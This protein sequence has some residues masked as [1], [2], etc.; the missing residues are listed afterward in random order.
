MKRFNFSLH[1]V[2]IVRE[3]R[4]KSRMEEYAGTL[5]VRMRALESLATVESEWSDTR[6]LWTRK[7]AEGCPASDLVQLQFAFQSVDRR[8]EAAVS[9]VTAAE[10]NV[11]KAMQAMLGARRDREAVDKCRD[12]QWLRHG[13]ALA[14]ADQNAMDEIATQRSRRPAVHSRGASSRQA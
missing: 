8:R 14:R 7:A 12:T 10:R 3:D 2:G 4:E 6:R 13:Q 5:L 11:Q 1:A 9:A